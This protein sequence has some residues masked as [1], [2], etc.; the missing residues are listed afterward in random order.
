[1]KSDLMCPVCHSEVKIENHILAG[2]TAAKKNVHALS[3]FTIVL[4]N[5]RSVLN[6]GSIFRTA[7][8]IGVHMI[9]CCGITPTPD[10]PKLAKTSLGAEWSIAWKHSLNA[11]NVVQDLKKSGYQILSLEESQ[12]SISI[13]EFQTK[14]VKMPMAV[15]VGN[16]VTGVD[17]GILAL[18][19]LVLDIPMTGYKRSLNVAVAFGIAVYQLNYSCLC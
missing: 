14:K 6:V 7:D 16:E 4:D 2:S 17:P 13:F 10:H 19:D 5:L 12:D 18:S 8:A 11:L 3:N 15:V 9:Y 1:M